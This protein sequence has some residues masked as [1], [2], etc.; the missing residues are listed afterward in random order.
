MCDTLYGMC[1]VGK[2]VKDECESWL[3]GL[4]FCLSMPENRSTPMGLEHSATIFGDA[5]SMYVARTHFHLLT[6]ESQVVPCQFWPITNE[7]FGHIF[8]YNFW[9]I[10][11][12]LWITELGVCAGVK[13]YVFVLVHCT[14]VTYS[15]YI[16]TWMSNEIGQL[17]Q[18]FVD[19]LKW[20]KTP[21]AVFCLA[22]KDSRIKQSLHFSCILGQRVTFL[23]IPKT[24]N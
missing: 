10:I 7:T 21:I 13:K 22:L 18:I 9:I 19:L 20:E 11:F 5:F 6:R 4:S 8:V 12:F 14:Y 23:Q 15:V 1:F 17:A 24:Q 2:L 3:C 16:H